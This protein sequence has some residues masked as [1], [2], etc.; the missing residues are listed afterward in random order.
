MIWLFCWLNS[1]SYHHHW[2][3]LAM[4]MYSSLMPLDLPSS[5]LFQG[6]ISFSFS[7]FV[8]LV[9]FGVWGEPLWHIVWVHFLFWNRVLDVILHNNHD[10]IWF[11][12][13]VAIVQ[14]YAIDTWLTFVMALCGSIQWQKGR[15]SRY[16]Q[17]RQRLRDSLSCNCQL[18]LWLIPFNIKT[19]SNKRQFTNLSKLCLVSRSHSVPLKY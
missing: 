1:L 5:R 12:I 6:V 4:T 15:E 18:S 11:S 9:L 3:A 10:L 14:D 17:K 19:H 2:A 7:T 8:E 13:L 16:V